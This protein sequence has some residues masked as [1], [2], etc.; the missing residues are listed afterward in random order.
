M[1]LLHLSGARRA[2]LIVPALC[3]PAPARLGH[4]RPAFPAR[5]HSACPP[6]HV[7][8]ACPASHTRSTHLPA[9]VLLARPPTRALLARALLAAYNVGLGLQI[10][11][12]IGA[13]GCPDGEWFVWLGAVKLREI[14][15]WG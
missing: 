9:C 8:S 12:S 7:R 14:R 5:V 6:A 13:I 2:Q 4:L 11:F 10:C 15:S 1:V 3:S